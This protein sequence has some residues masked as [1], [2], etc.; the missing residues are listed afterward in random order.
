MHLGAA[1]DGHAGVIKGCSKLTHLELCSLLLDALAGAVVDSVSSLT[2]LQH[3][4]ILPDANVPAE[5]RCWDQKRYALGGLSV[6]TLPR[7]Q[8][9]TCLNVDSLS[10][11]NLLQLG[12]LTNL[13]ALRMWAAVDNVGPKSI[14]GLIFPASLNTLVLMSSVE[15]S[16]LS[17]VP[18]GL[19][20]LWMEC[21]VEGPAEGPGSLLPCI[22]RLQHLTQLQLHISNGAIWP[23]AGPAYS[24]LTASSL[25]SFEFVI[26]SI[27]CCQRESGRTCFL[28]CASYHSSR[29]WL[30]EIM[31]A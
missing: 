19:Q 10:S 18:A 14:P 22:A 9:L 30:W 13:K 31:S 20:Y 27:V 6:A 5:A 16:I 3:L 7:S 24:A 8:H 23:P 15:A 4:S 28:H 29:V 1:A 12:A 25:L 2:D 17:V 21:D 26:L 11:E